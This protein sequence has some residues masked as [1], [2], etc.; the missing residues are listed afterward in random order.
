[1]KS[2]NFYYKTISFCSKIQKK[3]HEKFLQ[4]WNE[5]FSIRVIRDPIY[6]YLMMSDDYSNGLDRWYSAVILRDLLIGPGPDVLPLADQI[7]FFKEKWSLIT[8]LFKK[9]NCK[10]SHRLLF[11][12][13]KARADRVFG[14]TKNDI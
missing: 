4:Y 1:M 8:N 13:K 11:K 14:P 5:N 3:K 9:E 10:E 6:A 2:N 7:R 12:L